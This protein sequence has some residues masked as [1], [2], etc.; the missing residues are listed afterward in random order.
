MNK[1]KILMAFS[2]ITTAQS[3]LAA[4][5]IV[6]VR[7]NITLSDDE[8][9]AKDFYIKISEGGS[10]KKNLVVKAV[11]KINVKDAGLKTVGD[12]KTVVGLLKIIHTEGP[13]AVAREF[14]LLPRTDQ[15]M[16][17]QIG[18][19]T[20]DEIDL[21]ESFLD[22]AKPAEIKKKVAEA[23]SP[24]LQKTDEKDI[25]IPAAALTVIVAPIAPMLPVIQKSEATTETPN[26][27]PESISKD[28]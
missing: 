9:P 10:F 13:I 6:D 3:I 14:K 18:I 26:V 23:A 12:F 15:P 20:G 4:N 28:I 8:T 22:T 16:L 2:L 1:I 7:R 21:S 27:K 11:R 17:E 25:R 24:E 5:E 19:M